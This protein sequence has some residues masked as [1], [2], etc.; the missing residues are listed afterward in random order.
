MGTAWV[1]DKLEGVNMHLTNTVFILSFL[2]AKKQH[3]ETLMEWS[4]PHGSLT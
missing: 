2:W 3:W 1:A 4:F